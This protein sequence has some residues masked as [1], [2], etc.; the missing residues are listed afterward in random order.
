MTKPLTMTV[1]F[2]FWTAYRA[3]LILV[4]YMPLSLAVSLIFPCAGAYLIYLLVYYHQPVT[5]LNLVAIVVALFFTPIVLALSLFLARRKNPLAVGPFETSFDEEGLH[6]SAETFNSTIK[7]KAITRVVETRSFIFFFVAPR[8]AQCLPLA[9]V[10]LELL[11][12]LRHLI[13]RHVANVKG[14]D[15]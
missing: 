10:P 8:R 12:P 6:S 15:G 14:I 9:D 1:H 3:N 7:W 2:S 5:L 11:A 4:R 13:C